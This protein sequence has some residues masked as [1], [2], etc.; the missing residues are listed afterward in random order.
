ML[1]I[2][3]LEPASYSDKKL[4]NIL[5]HVQ[6]VFEMWAERLSLSNTTPIFLVGVNVVKPRFILLSKP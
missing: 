6:E 3:M 1:N 2:G 4:S 5:K